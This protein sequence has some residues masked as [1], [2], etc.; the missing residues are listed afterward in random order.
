MIART[1]IKNACKS[2]KND[3][4]PSSPAGKPESADGTSAL[5]GKPESADGVSTLAGMSESVEGVST[6]VDLSESADGVSTLAGMS[7]SVEGVSAL[8]DLSESA[9]GT[10][11]S[12]AGSPVPGIGRSSM[13]ISIISSGEA[14]SIFATRRA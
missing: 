9:A 10:L 13:R 12:L 14:P 5:A 3:Q 2:I 4:T 11:S 7:E 1:N 8:V 6:L